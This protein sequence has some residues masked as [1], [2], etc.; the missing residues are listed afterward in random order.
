MSVIFLSCSPIDSLNRDPYITLAKKYKRIEEHLDGKIIEIYL[1]SKRE[2]FSEG[3]YSDDVF[4]HDPSVQFIFASIKSGESIDE[5]S[6]FVRM[7]FSFDCNEDNYHFYKPRIQAQKKR[8]EYFYV[9]MVSHFGYKAYM[10]ERFTMNFDVIVPDSTNVLTV[11]FCLLN[12]IIAIL[13][14]EN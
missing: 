11:C 10:N 2:E 12:L 6:T 5:D 8:A 4:I 13:A 7:S 9:P 3:F 1:S 14:F